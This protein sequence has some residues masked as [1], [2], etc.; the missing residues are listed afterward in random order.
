MSSINKSEKKDGLGNNF[1]VHEAAARSLAKSFFCTRELTF[2]EEG[3]AWHDWLAEFHFIGAH[4]ITDFAGVL[5][6]PHHNDTGNLGH[7]FEL[8]DTRHDRMAREVT[9]KIRFIDRDSFHTDSLELAFKLNDAIDH[10]EWIAM[11]ES[12]HDAHD[13]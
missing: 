11:R 10:K 1:S 9:L 12:L 2:N 13:V 7:G 8:K 6:F 4:E 3:V 5:G